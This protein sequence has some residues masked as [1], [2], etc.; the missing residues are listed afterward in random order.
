MAPKGHEVWNA[1]AFRDY[2]KAHPDD[3]SRYANLKHKLAAEYKTDRERYTQAKTE[4]VNKI[5]AKAL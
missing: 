4:F 3:A 1:L 2:L 5:T